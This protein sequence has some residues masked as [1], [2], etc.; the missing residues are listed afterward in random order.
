[1]NDTIEL[2]M[3]TDCLMWVANGEPDPNSSESEHE[4]FVARVEDRWP[5]WVIVPG[6]DAEEFS[7]TSCDVCGSVLGG[8]RHSGT[9]F[10][11]E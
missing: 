4:A 8:A 11:P 9:A 7:W 5:G 2:R 3:C 10:K 1:M 6:D